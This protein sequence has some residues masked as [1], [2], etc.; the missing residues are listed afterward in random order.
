M[1]KICSS[2]QGTK[3]SS[4]IMELDAETFQKSSTIWTTCVHV[5]LYLFPIFN[6]VSKSSKPN[7][8]LVVNDSFDKLLPISHTDLTYS[9]SSV[10]H[11]VGNSHYSWWCP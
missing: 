6:E 1:C 5:S 11:P 7:L 4:R 3:H 9:G 10:I 8:P 2:I